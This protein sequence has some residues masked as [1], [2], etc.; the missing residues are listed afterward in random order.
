MLTMTKQLPCDVC[1]T[2]MVDEDIYEE[3]LGMCVECSWKYWSHE[4]EDNV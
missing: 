2:V 1:K 3:E 4:G